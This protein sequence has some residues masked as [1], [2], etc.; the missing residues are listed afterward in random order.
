M[1][2]P[3][4]P[5]RFNEE[6]ATF[7]VRGADAPDLDA[8]IAAIRAVVKTLPVRPGVYRML[9]ARGDVLYVGKARALK[10]RVNAYTQVARQTKRLLR[11]VTQTRSM[12]IVTTNSEA[13]ALLLEAQLIKRYRPPYN[14]LLRDDKSFP[15]ILLR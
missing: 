6:Q 13:K 11:M 3:N 12:Q 14:V 8:G 9:D 15:F 10:N 7:T 5:N 1:S 2:D 4:S